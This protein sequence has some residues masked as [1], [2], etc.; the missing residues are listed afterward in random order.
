MKNR[1]TILAS[2]VA[3]IGATTSSIA[4]EKGDWLLHVRAIN[5]SPNDDSSLLNV[6]GSNLAGTGV[7]VDS[8]STLDISIGYM[9]TDNFALELLADLSSE[10]DVNVFGLPAAL[11]VPDGTKIVES[12]VLP[13]T[14]FAQYHFNP[15]GKIRPYAG[16]GLNYTL[17][18]S[19]S[20]T[21]AAKSA[22]GASN[23]DIDSSFGLAG[24]FG[25][26]FEM[27]NDWSFNVD[28]KYIQIDTDATFDSALGRVKVGIDID[29]WVLGVGFGKTF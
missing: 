28:I 29:P 3:L 12:S 8:G 4:V 25:V 5:I 17:F 18:F 2:L 20:L 14:L 6:G 11:N 10:H 9:F 26:D 16:L 22:L 7:R 21:S 27:K 13:P 23:L 24:Q 1:N 15:K 19:D